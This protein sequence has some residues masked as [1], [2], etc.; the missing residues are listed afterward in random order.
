MPRVLVLLLFPTAVTII[1]AVTKPLLFC[2]LADPNCIYLVQSML[3]QVG[4][5]GGAEGHD[6]RFV[7]ECVEGG[8]VWRTGAPVRLRNVLL[9]SNLQASK[10]H[11]SV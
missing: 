9:D 8:D 4:A 7:V 6:S 11:A 2:L 5:S 3:L 10:Q 1:G